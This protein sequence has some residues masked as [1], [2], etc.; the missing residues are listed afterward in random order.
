[1]YK[2]IFTVFFN[3][4][5]TFTMAQEGKIET[6]RPDQTECPFTVPKKWLQFEAGTN[7]QKNTASVKEYLHPTL[8]TK[9]G[10]SKKFEL[11]IITTVQTGIYTLQP[12]Y[13]VTTKGLLPV[14]IGGKISLWE[15]K[16]LLPKTSL[17]FHAAFPKLAS[18]TY[19]AD[20]LAPNFRFTMQNTLSKNIALGYNLG[21]EWD[22]FTNTATWI[23]TFAPGFNL[24]EKWYAY[25]EAFGFITKGEA[26][27]HSL[28]AGIAY[29][30]TDNLK[31]DLSGGPG[32]SKNAPQR[33]IA[34]G[35]SFRFK[36]IK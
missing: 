16:K 17:I 32:I 9:Y 28:D 10:I 30:I 21:A 27:Q 36:A 14:E 22:G 35:A 24:S 5:A 13:T 31:F 29:F 6:D 7:A 26:P 23:Y 15:E 2:I 4:A 34:L 18:K 33:Y 8:L 1:M 3:I 19:N 25:I 20:K 11:R 12:G